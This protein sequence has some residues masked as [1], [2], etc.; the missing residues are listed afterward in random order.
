MCERERERER[1]FNQLEMVTLAMAMVLPD[2]TR[3]GL[4]PDAPAC[5][6]ST[7][8]VFCGALSSSSSIPYSFSVRRVRCSVAAADGSGRL[9]IVHRAR[10]R[11]PF[12]SSFVHSG[13]CGLNTSVIFGEATNHHIRRR[14]SNFVSQGAKCLKVLA[15]FGLGVPE[16]VVVAGVA[17]LLFGPKKLPEIGKSLGKTVKSFQQ[18]ADEF[19]IELKGGSG[20]STPES[21]NSEISPKASTSEKENA[22]NNV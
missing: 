10:K 18:A 11:A 2:F 14:S 5:C 21:P 1:D 6:S 8:S 4:L 7:S 17:A 9:R 19:Q 3:S 12:C 22:D 20:S 13:A 16:L 15:L